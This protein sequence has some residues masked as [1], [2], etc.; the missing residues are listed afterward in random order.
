MTE[1]Q[2]L[3]DNFNNPIYGYVINGVSTME[4]DNVTASAVRS[5][6]HP[7]GYSIVHLVTSSVVVSAIMLVIIVGNVLVVLAVSRDRSLSSPQNWFIASLALSDILVGLFIMPLSLAN[8]LMGYW[9]FGSVLCELWLS[10]DVLLCTAS[11]LNLVLISLD[12]YWSITR[13]V[14]Y[15][16]FRTRSR[17]AGMIAVVWTLSAVICFPPLVGWKRPQPVREDGLDQCLLSR[18]PGY[19]VYSTVGS[20]YI[21][22]VV[23]IAVYLKIYHVTKTRARRCLKKTTKPP[24]GRNSNNRL[25]LTVNEK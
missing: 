15:S 14:E 25:Q 22:L 10:T 12:R 16:R 6:T 8:E 13:A 21:P 17:A 11:I 4:P 24:A 5:S 9:V 18:E 7:T 2:V 19:I 20:F 1:Y 3:F 23:M